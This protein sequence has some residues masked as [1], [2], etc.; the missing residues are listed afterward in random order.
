ME[1][2]AIDKRLIMKNVILIIQGILVSA[3]FCIIHSI[4]TSS[5]LSVVIFAMYVMLYLKSAREFELKEKIVNCALSVLFA[6]FTGL[7]EILVIIDSDFSASWIVT[8]AVCWLGQFFLME[9]IIGSLLIIFRGN[10]FVKVPDNISEDIKI[11][12]VFTICMLVLITVWSM[13][14]IRV[15]PGSMSRDSVQI[16]NMALGKIDLL[17]AVPIVYVYPIRLIWNVGKTLFGTDNAGL[18]LCTFV[19]LIG[20]AVIV[21]YSISR[22]YANYVKKWICMFIL[23]YFALMPYNAYMVTTIWKDVPFS[24]SML[25]FMV[26]L[27]DFYFGKKAEKRIAEYS[28]L[29]FFIV[30]G[31]GVCLMRNN[32]LF[33][34]VLFIPFGLILF[35]KKN[36]KVFIS[37]IL[38]FTLTRIVQGPIYDKIMTTHSEKRAEQKT[39]E[40]VAVD[41]SHKEKK[42]KNATDSYNASAIYIITVQQL[43]NVAVDREDLSAEDYERLNKVVNVEKIRANY[44]EKSDYCRRCVDITLPLVRYKVP[45]AEYLRT[46]V[47]FGMKYPINYILGWRGQTI[48]YWYPD[49]QNWTTIDAIIE[50]DIGIYKVPVLQQETI[51]KI[52]SFENTYKKIPIYGMLWSIGF[53]VW[54]NL[55]FAGVAYV[56]IGL[57]GSMLYIMHIGV[58]LTLLVATPI[59][60]EFRYVY[61][62]YLCMP[63]SVLI[64]FLGDEKKEVH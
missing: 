60:A 28:R 37:L 57:K 45:E 27:V 62:F 4:K 64:P 7:G 47:Y 55:F 15:Y 56:K 39:E 52:V 17:A 29:F 20:M 23:L 18:A 16:A 35:Y 59:Y 24:A 63:L 6:L 38:I 5:I 19:Q 50:N 32:G 9:L 34:F 48:G 46:W 10:Y 21:A 11:G 14:W 58:W 36:K 3:S 22:L 33:A 30:S 44:A 51:N 8:F 26:F 49:I 13:G 41:D 42:V 25:L 31:M 12:K 61:S 2:T 54:L 40:M 43:A 53:M 1:I